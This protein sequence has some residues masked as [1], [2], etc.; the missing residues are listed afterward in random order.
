MGG[1]KKRA[2]DSRR[3]KEGVSKFRNFLLADLAGQQHHMRDSMFAMAAAGNLS[4][5]FSFLPRIAQWEA[6]ELSQTR[7]FLVI[8]I[9]EKEEGREREEVTQL[10]KAKRQRRIVV[11]GRRGVM[12]FLPFPSIWRPV[13]PVVPSLFEL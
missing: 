11:S 1:N 6:S 8:L 12:A 10:R 13:S 7:Q 5:P 3:R 4:F 9:D 2:G